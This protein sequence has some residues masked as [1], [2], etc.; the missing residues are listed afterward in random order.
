M[1]QF[2]VHWRFSAQS[3]QRL[4]H[5][6]LYA[7]ALFWI[8]EG[9]KRLHNEGAPLNC[10]AGQCLAMPAGETQLM[11]NLPN[12]SGY[13]Q[14]EVFTPPRLWTERFL[15]HYGPQLPT[16]WQLS[17]DFACVAELESQ[18]L[19]L[20]TLQNSA[21]PLAA[22]RGEHCWQGILL[23]LASRGLGAALFNLQP[24]N[25]SQRCR[26]LLQLDLAHPW[27]AAELAARLGLSES[28]LRRGLRQEQSSFSTL[29]SELR[30][31]C[32]FNRVMTEATPL[33]AIALDCGFASASRFSQNFRQRFGMSPSA[34][35]QSR[36]L[37]DEGIGDEEPTG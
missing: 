13:Y 25:L 12:A 16:Q 27:Q 20:M 32:A 9:T 14:A 1:S 31:A 3:A 10:P 2:S 28:S 36:G 34:L 35:R 21:D 4:H 33:L 22:A 18:L 29:L 11:E 5:V 23:T 26:A 7:P 8:R 24:L 17:P 19:T 15:T 37:H 30:L 6:P